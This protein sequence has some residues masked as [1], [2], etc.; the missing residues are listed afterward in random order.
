MMGRPPK[1]ERN[2]LIAKLRDNKGFTFKEIAKELNLSAP[3]AWEI[4]H[5]HK[6]NWPLIQ[7]RRAKK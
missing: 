2:K 5:R 6:G 3:T 4:Y 7:K 1:T